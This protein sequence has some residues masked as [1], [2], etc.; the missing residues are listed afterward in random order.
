M[1]LQELLKPLDSIQL[2]QELLLLRN[3]SLHKAILSSLQWEAEVKE[4]QILN[5]PTESL[6]E[7][8][9]Q[10]GYAKALRRIPRLLDEA[11]EFLKQ[12]K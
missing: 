7:E 2:Q 4:K 11:E 8:S 9:F 3:S 6:T 12:T 10:K 1:Q 5:Q